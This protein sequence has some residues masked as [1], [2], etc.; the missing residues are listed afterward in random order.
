MSAKFDPILGKLRTKDLG[1]TE[2]SFGITIDGGGSVISTGVKGYVTIPYNCTIT[3]WDIFADQSG[4][5]VVDLWKDTYANFAPTIA[6]TI[7]GTEKPT[8]SSQQKNQDNSLSTWTTSVNAGDIIAFN[9]DSASTVQR[10]NVIIK[11]TK[12]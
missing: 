4:S 2:A 3:G 9:V 12:I 10:V 7:T 11:V 6:D 5:C 1:I 8:L